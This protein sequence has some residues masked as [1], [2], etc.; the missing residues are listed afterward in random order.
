MPKKNRMRLLSVL[1]LSKSADLLVSPKTTLPWLI[2]SV[3]APAWLLPLILPIKESGSLIPQ[4]FIRHAVFA[5]FPNRILLWRA[6]AIAQSLSI[7]AIALSALIASP[8]HFAYVCVAA[9]IVMSLGRAFCSLSMKEIQAEWV[10]KGERGHVLGQAD[11]VS[12]IVTI[13]FA[14]LYFT[15]SGDVGLTALVC[16]I[17]A[18][19]VLVASAIIVTVKCQP[20]TV[21]VKHI[22]KQKLIDGVV[23]LNRDDKLRH[24]VISRVLAVHGI[25]SVPFIVSSSLNDNQTGIAV[26]L[27][28]SALA[29]LFSANL[30]GNKADT[31]A[32]HTLRWAIGL[33]VVAIVVYGLSTM[34]EYKDVVSYVVF[35][36]LNISHTGIRLAR[37]TYL[38]DI[39]DEQNRADYVSIGNTFV[40]VLL[41]L[42][43]SVYAFAYAFIGQYLLVVLACIAGLGVL[44]SR[45]L[46]AVN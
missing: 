40:G 29:S 45:Y 35:L 25:L 43:G 15:V 33:S 34:T 46:K 9:L 31:N 44:H 41:V 24:I 32:V 36:M 27:T 28:L 1:G 21:H 39:T 20:V 26:F 18:G 23:Q 17:G 12:G 37:K 22:A 42:L 10:E 6:G 30:W 7:L 4:W 5:H 8:T 3:G 16:L 38:L 13:L 2:S 14:L 19:A 11:V